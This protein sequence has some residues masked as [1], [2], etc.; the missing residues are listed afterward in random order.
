MNDKLKGE[1]LQLSAAEKLELIGEL[2]D[3]IDQTTSELE[4]T[5][6]ELAEFERRMEE[7]RRDPSSAIPVEEVIA[8]LRSRLACTTG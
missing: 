5:L 7:H 3:S 2:W 1:L 6:E 4:F 8:D